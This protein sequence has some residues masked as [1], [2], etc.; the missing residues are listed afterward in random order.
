MD[1]VMVLHNKNDNKKVSVWI[2]FLQLT[3]IKKTEEIDYT[4][5]HYPYMLCFNSPL[6]FI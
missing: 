2:N 4:N 6:F 5:S 1:D 3:I